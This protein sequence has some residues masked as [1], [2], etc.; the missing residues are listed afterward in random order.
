[1][2]INAFLR[3]IRTIA[4]G[5]VVLGASNVLAQANVAATDDGAVFGTLDEM[6]NDVD[7]ASAGQTLTQAPASQGASGAAQPQVYY[8][9]GMEI[10]LKET[11]IPGSAYFTDSDGNRIDPSTLMNQVPAGQEILIPSKDGP[12][13]SPG[14]SF[15]VEGFYDGTL[16]FP[17]GTFP[18]TPFGE[19][20]ISEVPAGEAAAGEAKGGEIVGALLDEN[21][22]PA[23]A[24]AKP[25]M[26]N[27]VPIDQV[28]RPD[29]SPAGGQTKDTASQ[30]SA[31]RSV[32]EAKTGV[33]GKKDQSSR[34]SQR[35]QTAIGEQ[36]RLTGLL[37][38][39]NQKTET[40]AKELNQLKAT[41][42]KQKEASRSQVSRLTK[43]LRKAKA[44]SKKKID[45]LK[46][47][48][49]SPVPKSGIVKKMMSELEV[50]TK[51]NAALRIKT[52]AEVH[53]AR[54][55]VESYQAKL[56]EMQ[57]AKEQADKKVEAL[58]AKAKEDAAKVKEIQAAKKEADKKV[59][60]LLAK[61]KADAEKAKDRIAS[62]EARAKAVR[63]EML[64]LTQKMTADSAA[65][66]VSAPTGITAGM[67]Q[68]DVAADTSEKLAT[69]AMDAK[70]AAELEVRRKLKA[71]Q[72]QKKLADAAADAAENAGAD[73]NGRGEI[74]QPEDGKESV[75]SL[76]DQIKRLKAKRD[77][78]IAESETRIRAKQ[79]RE[80]D[81]LL[82]QGK[83]V[84]S[85]EVK[86]AV[87]K[88]KGAIKTSEEKLRSR[89]LRRLERLKE[90]MKK[91]L[92]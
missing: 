39:A 50:K 26:E 34:N 68:A 81:R 92:K 7:A 8:P 51:E 4:C 24:G 63:A 11:E 48:M 79:Q 21:G 17:M 72:K 46:A 44:E 52:D 45:E 12:E 20:I 71:M 60:M 91:R 22:N 28:V 85:D 70:A 69:K 84:D 76:D 38:K 32:V 25:A 75:L 13:L 49:K 23:D 65:S 83:A 33:D 19:R 2:K 66:N 56:K 5:V 40:L 3:L 35:L 9:P 87:E 61:A 37:K 77:R 18:K 57:V 10:P 64:A 88:M 89:F 27:G 82:E 58:V 42:A 59:E 54:A 16:A 15:S 31:S 43:S 86:A 14:Q 55:Q 47:K 30:G 53:Q 73:E 1:M 80:I 36:Q 41:R 6:T 67:T 74:V 78:Q 29:N 90:S 62:A